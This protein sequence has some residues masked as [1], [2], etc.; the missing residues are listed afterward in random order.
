MKTGED[1]DGATGMTEVWAVLTQERAKNGIQ[2]GPSQIPLP[3]CDGRCS[4]SASLFMKWHYCISM[5]VSQD[6]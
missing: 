1:G 3:L 4:L 5:S 2:T 6:V